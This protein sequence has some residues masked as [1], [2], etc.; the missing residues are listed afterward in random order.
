M[1][2]PRVSGPGL[3]YWGGNPNALYRPSLYTSHSSPFLPCETMFPPNFVFAEHVAASQALDTRVS[4][5]SRQHGG[6]EV[7]AITIRSCALKHVLSDAFDNSLGDTWMHQKLPIFIGR[8]K[9]PEGMGRVV[10]SWGNTWTHKEL[11]IFIGW[12]KLREN[13]DRVVGHDST[14]F[15]RLDGSNLI[16]KQT[17]DIS[18]GIFPYKY[19]CILFFY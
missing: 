13:V 19:R 7:H 17:I 16:T 12:V 3:E 2:G 15:A 18:R 6:L 14:S 5:E 1:K 11:P 4:N 10:R 8:M 9:Q